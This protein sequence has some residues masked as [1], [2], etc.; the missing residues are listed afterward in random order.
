MAVD[1]D[2]TVKS[3]AAGTLLFSIAVGLALLLGES[4][5]GKACGNQFKPLFFLVGL[6]AYA[7]L[8]LLLGI[9]LFVA[10]E[11]VR[12]ARGFSGSF[13]TISG[14]TECLIS[15]AAVLV[16]GAIVL[17]E[18]ILSRSRFFSLLSVSVDFL[19]VMLIGTLFWL[20][21]FLARGLPLRTLRIALL[22]G[23]A[24]GSLCLSLLYIVIERPIKPVFEIA[25]TQT[26]FSFLL[27]CVSLVTP[28]VASKLAA[29]AF[30]AINLASMIAPAFSVVSLASLILVL[31]SNTSMDT[32][33]KRPSPKTMP[34]D[35]PNVILIVVD[36]LRADRLSTYG[37]HRPTSPNLDRFADESVKFER[38]IS[39]ANWTPPGHASI[40]TGRFPISHGAHKTLSDRNPK[41]PNCFPLAEEETTI[42]EI[43]AEQGYRTAGVVANFGFVSGALGLDQGFQFWFARP[44]R[45]LKPILLTLA[46][47]LELVTAR[48]LLT[49][50]VPYRR[51]SDIKEVSLRW[52]RQYGDRPFFLFIN[53]MDPHS[54][55]SPPKPWEGDPGDSTLSYSFENYH[56]D[57]RDGL[58]D[59]SDRHWSHINSQYDGE[60]A[61]VDAEIG[62]FLFQL[63]EQNIYSNSIV[64]VTS[65]HGEFLGEKGL[66]D[67]QIGLY[68]PVISVPLIFKVADGTIAPNDSDRIAQTVDI[69][70]T[71]LDSIDIEIPDFVQG[72][73]LLRTEIHPIISQHYVDLHIYDWYDGRFNV[74]QIS[75][76]QNTKKLILSSDGKSE[77]LE[78]A[79][80]TDEDIEHGG[81][82]FE[83][84]DQMLEILNIWVSEVEKRARLGEESPSLDEATI[85]RLRSLGY[86]D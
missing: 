45:R 67:H 11:I 4:V 86:V 46:L 16:Q 47:K 71:V 68:Q 79:G 56:D 51:A 55:Y 3:R 19:W 18:L 65:D 15:V 29:R 61:Y 35:K 80:D 83:I 43:L 20:V 66:L 23:V 72:T 84:R 31:C 17:N 30:P 75:L 39:P 48:R 34:I 54:P 62:D 5:V 57:I 78:L 64:I 49:N 27:V 14:I 69:L 9:A 70:P 63:K 37:Y 28:L 10:L 7:A 25:C 53:F 52:I 8:G 50:P 40:F 32:F 60:I 24:L 2:V 36:T 33:E 82:E 59:L 6:P 44:P 1:L 12:P 41:Y 21:S 77:F 38:C 85:E 73:S 58:T 42:A 26:I 22:S 13:M 76:I 74:D 81:E